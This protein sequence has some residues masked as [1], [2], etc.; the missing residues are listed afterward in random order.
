MLYC[1]SPV[2]HR[3]AMRV[4]NN[5]A[6]TI[7]HHRRPVPR[8]TVFDFH[9]PILTSSSPPSTRPSLFPATCFTSTQ[10]HV[11]CPRPFVPI[12]IYCCQPG[13]SCC[14]CIAAV[15]LLTRIFSLDVEVMSDPRQGRWPTLSVLRTNQRPGFLRQGRT[16]K[17]PLSPW[18]QCSFPSKTPREMFYGEPVIRC[19]HLT[20]KK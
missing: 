16:S 5:Q 6:A 14:R 19:R 20:R 8:S 2:D 4:S 7:H 18:H 15:V 9:A 17:A 12:P 11:P 1:R 10:H 3:S 13:W